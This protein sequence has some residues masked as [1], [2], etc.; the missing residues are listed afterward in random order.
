VRC[1]VVAALV[2]GCAHANQP[3]C[4][5]T[6]PL[7][8]APA[9]PD[10]PRAIEEG[11][12]DSIEITGGPDLAPIASRVLESQVGQLISIAPLS[13]D[14]RRL[15]ALGLFSDIR[16]QARD[17]GVTQTVAR[18]AYPRMAITFA[19]T[20][21]GTIDRV[22]VEGGGAHAPELR[23][24]HWIAGT[25]FEPRRLARMADA[26]ELAYV[27]DG[28]LDARIA[29]RRAR[30]PGVSLCVIAEPGPRVTIG[31]VTFPGH[32][33]VSEG[34]L[35]AAMHGKHVNHPGDPYDADALEFDRSA[36]LG[37]YW[38]RGMIN[39]RVEPARVARRGN[40]LD[41]AIPIEPGAVY[42]IGTL[43]VDWGFPPLRGIAT[44][45]VFERTRVLDAA[46]ALELKLGPGASVYPD[47]SIDSG[48]LRVDLNFHIQWSWPW[49]A[50][51]LL[52]W[53]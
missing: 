37:P 50:L 2:S 5:G 15:W 39:A 13:D 41:V 49:R 22:R 34:E 6:L 17:T 9:A 11:V 3:A 33:A 23:R 36:L 1:V 43:R 52:P 29:V 48:T 24:M 31:H 42:R 7:A 12:I 53:S 32:G 14:V 20:T 25:P 19:V 51:H 26:I 46:K 8:D 4:S 40:H 18:Q 10:E 38:E 35:A 21:R 44:G 16:V 47:S 45:Q 30:L 27:R 28:H